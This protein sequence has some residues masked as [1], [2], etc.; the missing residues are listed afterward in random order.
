KSA[1]ERTL[2]RYLASYGIESPPRTEPER[3][4]AAQA[5]PRVLS[6]VARMKPK[7]TIVHVLSTAPEAAQEKLLGEAVRRL[8]RGGATVTWSVPPFEAALEPPWQRPEPVL[9]DAGG[10]P[11]PPRAKPAFGP[12][13]SIAAEA[14]K[15]RAR[16]AQA[17]GERLLRRLGVK[18]VR[19]RNVAAA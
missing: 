7:P 16:V 17:G 10:E 6:A 3:P 12:A 11:A 14:V 18:I 15:V 4:M 8:S 1:R 9:L 13:A 2:R 19:Q 5:L